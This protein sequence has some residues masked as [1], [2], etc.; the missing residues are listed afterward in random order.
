MPDNRAELRTARDRHTHWETTTDPV[1]PVS[2]AALQVTNAIVCEQVLEG[3]HGLATWR[4]RAPAGATLSGPEPSRGG[5]QFWVVLAGTLS[6]GESGLLPVN[7]T[8]FVA[9][10]DG[11]LALAAGPGG[12]E[13]LCLQFRVPYAARH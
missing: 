9:P 3:E 6:A 2:D 1:P 4:Y 5:G 13:A 8:I 7:S 12:A 10:D 11:P